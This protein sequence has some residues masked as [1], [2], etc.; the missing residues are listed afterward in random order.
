MDIHWTNTIMVYNKNRTWMTH[1]QWVTRK[2]KVH[3]RETE[4][5]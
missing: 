1:W 4:K 2:E 5:Q 3:K